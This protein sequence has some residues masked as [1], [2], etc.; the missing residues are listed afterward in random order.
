MTV[1]CKTFKRL[2]EAGASKPFL[3]T[4]DVGQDWVVKNLGN[5]QGDKSLFNELVAGRLAALIG[6][7]WPPVSVVN[8]S[9]EVMAALEGEGLRPTSHFAVGLEYIEGLQPVPWPE[10]G[11]SLGPDFAKRNAAHILKLVPRGDFRDVLYGKMIFDCWVL[12]R[13]TKYDAFYLDA[14]G[15]PF[16]LDASC[17]FGG[18]EWDEE[19]LAWEP[20]AVGVRSPY[21]EGILTELDRFHP[22]LARLRALPLLKIQECVTGLPCE[23]SVPDTYV[24][25]AVQLLGVTSESFVPQIQEWLEW[26]EASGGTSA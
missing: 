20:T 7:P 6:L 17:A 12:L 1:L 8:L 24:K 25:K 4:S 2:M 22:W 16:F 26:K 10:G 14:E 23:W 18:T 13:D 15:K 19:L 9:D 21:L 11:Y 5:P 3:A